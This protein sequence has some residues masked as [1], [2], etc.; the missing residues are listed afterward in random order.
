MRNRGTAG[1]PRASS[2]QQRLGERERSRPR[3]RARQ[4]FGLRAREGWVERV[5]KLRQHPNEA[6]PIAGWIGALIR[7]R[8]CCEES[9]P[10]HGGPARG[11]RYEPFQPGNVV[12]MK[13]GAGVQE[14]T[15]S[16]DERTLQL[17]EVIRDSQPTWHVA[18]EGVIQRLAIV[19]GTRSS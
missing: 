1:R 12:R 10:G 16:K 3:A 5:M 17:A 13:P 11:Y 18:D 4:S 7:E 6:L 14:S 2:L 15:L 8:G 19:Y 9:G